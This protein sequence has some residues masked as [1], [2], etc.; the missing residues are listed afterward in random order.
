MNYQYTVINNRLPGHPVV[1]RTHSRELATGWLYMSV[2]PKCLDRVGRGL[3]KA[4]KRAAAALQY[5]MPTIGADTYY[6]D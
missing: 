5:G 3:L 4:E 6:N 1:I 2:V